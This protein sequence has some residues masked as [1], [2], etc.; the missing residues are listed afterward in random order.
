LNEFARTS[1]V[2]ISVE[3]PCADGQF[4]DFR[5]SLV[6]DDLTHANAH[7]CLRRH[8]KNPWTFQKLVE[9]KWCGDEWLPFFK[10]LIKEN[11]N[12][13]V[14]GSTGSGKT[15]V[16]NSLLDL[17][18]QNERVVVIEDSSVDCSFQ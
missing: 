13:L 10:N 3:S 5:L 15:S 12:C 8:P 9:N 2:H 7:M 6:G 1:K 17:L 18:P 16:L 14:I 11:S 4:L